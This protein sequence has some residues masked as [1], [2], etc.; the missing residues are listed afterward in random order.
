MMR[1]RPSTIKLKDP[2]ATENLIPI[3]QCNVKHF[4]DMNSIID[5]SSIQDYQRRYTLGTGTQANHYF[6][7]KFL[8]LLNATF[9]I[10]ISTI[11]SPHSLILRVIDTINIKELFI[12]KRILMV[13]SFRKFV[14][15]Q[16]ANFSRLIF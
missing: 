15:T 14:R 2:V 10:G 13:S 7:R 6:R 11:Y 16:F 8:S 12:R 5:S 4:F 9:F 1:V 3:F